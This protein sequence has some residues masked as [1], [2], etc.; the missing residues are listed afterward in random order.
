M[1]LPPQTIVPLLEALEAEATRSHEWRV[2]LVGRRLARDARLRRRL[3]TD[4]AVSVHDRAREALAALNNEETR[5]DL[6]IVEQ[7]LVDGRGVDLLRELRVHHRDTV[8]VMVL[9]NDATQVVR[10]AI[11]DAAIYQVIM[12]PWQPEQVHLLVRRALEA[13]ELSRIHRYL[14]RQLKF[15]DRT[16]QPPDPVHKAMRE[17]YTFDRLVF[18]STA[19][20]EVCNFARKA[21][22]TDLPVLIEGETGTGK[23]PMARAIHLF[24]QRHNLLFMH[25]NCAV[26]TDEALRAVLF[27][28]PD[29][30][31]G[32]QPGL[33]VAAEGGSVFLD[34]I[35]DISQAT[36]AALLRFLQAGEPPQAGRGVRII[37]SSDRPLRPLVAQGKFRRDLYYRLRG[38]ELRIPPLRERREDIPPLVAHLL[39]K[40][41]GNM[42][43]HV[44]GITPEALACLGAY[45]FPGNVRELE[46]E[47]R[48]IMALIDDGEFITVRHLSPE[49]SSARPAPPSPPACASLLDLPGGTLKE[50]V[51]TLEA[52]LVRDA[53]DCC[54]WNHSKAARE[55]GL[56][57]VGLANKIKRYAIRRAGLPPPAGRE[58]AD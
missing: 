15:T 20:A 31:R 21:S 2:A 42:G 29:G 5:A 41:S 48:R 34:G 16:V 35:S 14:S 30:E 4:Y 10:D 26:E 40:Y 9:D 24:S 23:E 3:G 25:V 55:L 51:E 19:M 33:L 27:G 58:R 22:L 49:I 56:S 18:A 13:R 28:R 37:A 39:E 47:V 1:N 57:R 46:N 38:F 6:V 43:R 54:H 36:Q 8:R 53:L 17:I 32:T 52:Q 12:A 44:A 7:V 45:D 50:K 11:N